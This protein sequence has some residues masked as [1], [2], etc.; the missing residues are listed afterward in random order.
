[1]NAA[2]TMQKFHICEKNKGTCSAHCL[3]ITFRWSLLTC[4]DAS[5]SDLGANRSPLWIAWDAIL[6]SVA[7]DTIG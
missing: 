3:Q 4:C 5:W 7:R 1:M 2:A 6:I